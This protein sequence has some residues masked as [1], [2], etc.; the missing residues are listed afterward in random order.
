M[1]ESSHSSYYVP[2]LV[3]PVK[4]KT[5]KNPFVYCIFNEP[6]GAETTYTKHSAIHQRQRAE[7]DHKQKDSNDWKKPSWLFQSLEFSENYLIITPDSP[8]GEPKHFYGLTS[9][10]TR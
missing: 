6:K 5:Y 3:P 1:R 4:Q 2:L 9:D 8:P 7:R 10:L